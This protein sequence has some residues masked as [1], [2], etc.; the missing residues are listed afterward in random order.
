VLACFTLVAGTVLPEIW[1]QAVDPQSLIREWTGDWSYLREFS[2]TENMTIAKIETNQVYGHI[3]RVSGIK[4]IQSAHYDFVG[5]LEGDKLVFTGSGGDSVQLTI[6]GI[7]M[8]GTGFQ[9]VRYSIS[10]RKS[11]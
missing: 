8:Q 2:G 10:M 7:T 1:A 9:S 6:S 4:L 5:T 3:D 11:K